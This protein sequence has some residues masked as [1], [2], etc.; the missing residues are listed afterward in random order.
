MLPQ[1]ST[2]LTLEDI[3]LTKYK[4]QAHVGGIYK[5]YN[6]EQITMSDDAERLAG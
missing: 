2:Y 3:D 1:D 4:K 6:Q 5:D